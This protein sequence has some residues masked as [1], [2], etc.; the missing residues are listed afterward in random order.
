MHLIELYPE[1]IMTETNE[2]EHISKAVI[3]AKSFVF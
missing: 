1:E 3:L 2:E